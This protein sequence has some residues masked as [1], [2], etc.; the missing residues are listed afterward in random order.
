MSGMIDA[1]SAHRI[2]PVENGGRGVEPPRRAVAMRG[3]TVDPESCRDRMRDWIFKQPRVVGDMLK[4]LGSIT[5]ELLGEHAHRILEGTDSV[6][7]LACGGS[8]HAALLARNW[9]E[10]LAK[11]PVS[12]E[13]ASEFRYRDSVANPRSLVVAVSRKDDAA[14]VIG[15]IELAGR[16]G[17]QKTLAIC[18]APGDALAHECALSFMTAAVIENGVRSEKPCITTLIALFL[19]ALV[20]A[21]SRH[22]LA[23]QDERRQLRALH[24][25]PG[26][27][28]EVL[29]LDPGITAWAGRL[30]RSSNMLFLGRG[31]HHPVAMEG[32]LN[33]KENA[34]I[35]AEAF[36]AGELKHGPLALVSAEMPVVVTA[37]NDRLLEKLKSNLQA[38]R[39]R[40]GKLF[41]FADTNCSL[42]TGA[43]L[44]V[45]RLGEHYGLLSPVLHIIPMQLLACHAAFARVAQ[46]SASKAPH[47]SAQ[48]VAAD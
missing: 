30:A 28:N 4:G 40:N 48:T 41:V 20:L 45:M 44:E 39:A 19:L 7:I 23:S 31:M 16:M 36:P 47:D 8:Y 10:S 25:L 13:F 43:N 42:P 3:Q 32:A 29:A 33:M 35:H 18:D 2:A 1:A 21:R 5:P 26:A 14:D 24:D 34:S 38:V 9:I 27:M 15:A 46:W 37:P 6:L 17:M 22:V 12:I 11:V